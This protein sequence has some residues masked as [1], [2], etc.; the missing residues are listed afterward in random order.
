M[1]LAVWNT[2]NRDWG[3]LYAQKIIHLSNDAGEWGPRLPGNLMFP[4]LM[5]VIKGWVGKGERVDKLKIKRV[6]GLR[7]TAYGA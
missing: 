4:V 5:V 6:F 3:I 7:A 2:F 1:L